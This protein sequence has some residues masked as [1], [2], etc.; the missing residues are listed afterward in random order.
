MARHKKS[1]RQ[2]LG[3]KMKYKPNNIED[4][5][6]AY[7][8]PVPKKVV[9]KIYRAVL[10]NITPQ[11]FFESKIWEYWEQDPSRTANQVRG[12]LCK[13]KLKVIPML[14]CLRETYPN[15]DLV[16][17]FTGKEKFCVPVPKSWLLN[18]DKRQW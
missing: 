6:K 7:G 8:V 10:K 14:G 9:N 1:Y 11:Q 5:C 13:L 2:L 18:T 12:K 16:V 15:M 17:D 3:G 4:L